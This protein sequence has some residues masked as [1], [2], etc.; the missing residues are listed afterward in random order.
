LKPLW[1]QES[2]F[3]AD[4]STNDIKARNGRVDQIRMALLNAD[5]ETVRSRLEAVPGVRGI[6]QLNGESSSELAIEVI[7][8]DRDDPRPD[9]FAAIKT[10][11]WV[12]IELRREA[13]TLETIFR[14]LTREN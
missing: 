3:L 8:R 1:R 12:L 13:K 11:D 2:I 4:G 5:F 6:K 7:C 14:E 10:T 9:L